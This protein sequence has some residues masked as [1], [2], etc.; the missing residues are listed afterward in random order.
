MP[1]SETG[2]QAASL[3]QFLHSVSIPTGATKDQLLAL[4]FRAAQY[5]QLAEYLHSFEEQITS[6]L[7]GDPSVLEG[8]LRKLFSSFDQ[9]LQ[10]VPVQV[11][12]SVFSELPDTDETNEALTLRSKQVAETIGRTGVIQDA[13][14]ER[15]TQTNRE[16]INKLVSKYSKWVPQK[17]IGVAEL[18]EK[19]VRIS[20]ENKTMPPEK[21]IEAATDAFDPQTK[22]DL[23]TRLNKDKNLLRAVSA[24]RAASP[25]VVSSHYISAILSSPDPTV[26]ERTLQQNISSLK[27][28]DTPSLTR[29][30]NDASSLS[31][32]AALIKTTSDE[33]ITYAGFFQNISRGGAVGEK[34]LAPAADFIFSFFPNNAKEAVVTK[35]LGSSWTKEINGGVVDRILG[36]N[37]QLPMVAAAIQGV[38]TLFSSKSRGAAIFSKTQLFFADLFVTIFHPTVSETYIR[39]SAAGGVPQHQSVGLFY[40]GALAQWGADYAARKGIK[41][42]GKAFAKKAAGTAAG[43]AVGALVGSAAPGIGTFIGALVGDVIIDKVLGGLW[44]GAKGAFNFLTLDWLGKLVSGQYEAGPITK[45]PTFIIAAVLVGVLALFVLPFSPLPIVSTA[46][47]KQEVQD[48]AFIGGIGGLSPGQGI[49]CSKDPTNPLCSLA[50]C[51][52]AIQ[53]CRWPTSGIITQGPYTICGGTHS[54]SNAIDIGTGVNGVD[55]YSTIHGTVAE[56]FTGCPDD[57]GYLGNPCGGY[58]GNHIVINGIAPYDYT[59]TFGHLLQSTI[60]VSKGQEVF[61]TDVI[62]EADHT[63]SSSGP[64]LHFSFK[65]NSGQGRSINAILPFAITNCSNKTA[66]C[67]PCNYPAVGGGR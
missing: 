15:H 60:Y 17:E 63:G 54:Q 9:Q 3:Q 36:Q 24:S 66:G 55:V 49:D 57:D 34:I 65:D 8:L 39:L 29:A 20:E 28:V 40:V 6:A 48:S 41:T 22:R 4:Y 26:L 59:L 44:R 45:D 56:V 43:K 32:V 38:N 12:E 58:L 62:G 13:V 16:F 5:P 42:A 10:T 1:T 7:Q 25:P 14:R 11:A 31:A 18:S 64:H 46:Q 30:I 67:M 23:I 35:I 53:D 19:I 2:P 61:P 47:H 50:A 33:A 21:I 37:G 27:R 52:P 51:D